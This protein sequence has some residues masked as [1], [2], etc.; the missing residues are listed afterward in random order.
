MNIFNVRDLKERPSAIIRDAEQ[1]HLSMVTKRGHPVFIALPFSEDLIK[2][3]L[4]HAL[5]LKM[6]EDD[7]ITLQQAAKIANLSIEEMMAL[8]ANAKTVVVNYDISEL[9]QEMAIDE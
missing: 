2:L 9:D 1:G 8:T 3:G 7:Q 4:P 6:L 5:A